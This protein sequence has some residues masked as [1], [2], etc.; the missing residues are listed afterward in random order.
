MTGTE[1]VADDPFIGAS[2]GGASRIV[3]AGERAPASGSDPFV[4][5][6]RAERA[7]ERVTE[8][9]PFSEGGTSKASGSGQ[10]PFASGRS[11]G[12][13]AFEIGGAPNIS[14]DSIAQMMRSVDRSLGTERETA[15]R[16]HASESME[17]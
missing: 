3:E 5:G 10:D 4:A 17:R 8:R 9:D 15:P 11:R 14:K 2:G 7:P 16:Q 13:E 1:R 6:R 12:D